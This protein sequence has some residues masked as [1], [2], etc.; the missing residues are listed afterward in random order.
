MPETRA[1]LP[2]RC[3][4]SPIRKMRTGVFFYFF[5]TK[6][7]FVLTSRFERRRVPHQAFDHTDRVLVV[8]A[9]FA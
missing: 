7:F 9:I 5:A 4:A 3:D 8:E 1:A 6:L 2:K